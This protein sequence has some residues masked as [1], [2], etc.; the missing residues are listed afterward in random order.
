MK[1]TYGTV[2]QGIFNAVAAAIF[3]AVYQLLF[4]LFMPDSSCADSRNNSGE[5]KRC[6]DEETSRG[7]PEGCVVSSGENEGRS[8]GL[9]ERGNSSN[10]DLLERER[11]AGGGISPRSDVEC[12]GLR[13]TAGVDRAVRTPRETVSFLIDLTFA[14]SLLH[15]VVVLPFILLISAIGLEVLVGMCRV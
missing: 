13:A 14:L 4:R 5:G 9:R 11:I 3:Y 7:A 8:G 1:K 6:C 15:A 2:W 10:E 12:G